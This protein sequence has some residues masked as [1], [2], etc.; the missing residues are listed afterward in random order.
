MKVRESMSIATTTSITTSTNPSKE[1][2][3]ALQNEIPPPPVLQPGALLREPA[4]KVRVVGVV[5]NTVLVH[6][7]RSGTS[8]HGS[9]LCEYAE[10]AEKRGKR[11]KKEQKDGEGRGLSRQ[12]TSQRSA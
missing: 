10:N 4:L 2:L 9:F 8:R 12:T 7:G 11:V 6:K 5:P 1:E 3:A